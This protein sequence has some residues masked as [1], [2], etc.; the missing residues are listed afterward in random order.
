M[1]RESAVIIYYR[2]EGLLHHWVVSCDGARETIESLKSHLQK[3]IPGSEFV[4]ARIE[5]L[6]LPLRGD[7][8]H[9]EKM[10]MALHI[11]DGAARIEIEG[12]VLS[13]YDGGWYAY[14]GNGE[15]GIVGGEVVRWEHIDRARE[16]RSVFDAY[17]AC[18]DHVAARAKTHESEVVECTAA[19]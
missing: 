11:I 14:P 6:S 7:A 5:T 10:M 12:H 13:F 9:H 18:V 1:S 19:L 8:N 4:E 2:L 16:F 15:A 3:W 17:Q